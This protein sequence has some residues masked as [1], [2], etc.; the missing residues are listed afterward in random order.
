MSKNKSILSIVLITIGLLVG[1]GGILMSGIMY[2]Q[3]DNKIWIWSGTILYAVSWIPYGVGLIL[4]SRGTL[5]KLRDRLKKV[6]H[7]ESIP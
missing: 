7:K 2:V 4:L 3:T 6:F 1:Y 5:E